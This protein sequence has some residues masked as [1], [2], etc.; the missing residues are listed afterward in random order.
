MWWTTGKKTKKTPEYSL[1]ALL[2]MTETEDAQD[3]IR[4]DTGSLTQT[5]SL[6][7]LLSSPLCVYV[8]NV[9]YSKFECERILEMSCIV[10]YWGA[11]CVTL[12]CSFIEF[13]PSICLCA[14][15]NWSQL[16]C[17]FRKNDSLFNLSISVLHSWVCCTL[18]ARGEEATAT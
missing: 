7:V 11:A 8:T 14:I 18:G 10:R 3:S 5:P 16:G 12:C 9:W 15:F 1:V 6:S 17:C 13:A 4:T 2:H